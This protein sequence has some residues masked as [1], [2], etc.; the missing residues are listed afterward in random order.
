MEVRA[1][2]DIGYGNVKK[3]DVIAIRKIDKDDTDDCGGY[4]Y[5]EE[6][7]YVGVSVDSFEQIIK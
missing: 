1:K 7:P 2:K 6:I 3:G 4:L 5:F